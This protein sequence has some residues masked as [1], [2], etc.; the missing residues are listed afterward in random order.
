M[1]HCHQSRLRSLSRAESPSQLALILAT[2]DGVEI[3]MRRFGAH[4]YET[5][6]GDRQGAA[7]MLAVKAPGAHVD[8]APTWMV[9]DASKYS[10]MEYERTQ[11]VRGRGR[12]DGG[13]GDERAKGSG[14]AAA[15]GAQAAEGA[16]GRGGRGDR[17]RGGRGK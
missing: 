13:K 11:R 5:L 16:R 8:I 3:D 7:A 12:G 9:E 14:G 10:K 17:G 1:E 4:V 15:S 2:D 6:T